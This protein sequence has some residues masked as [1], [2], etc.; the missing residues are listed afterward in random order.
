MKKIIYN[1]LIRDKIPEI[2]RNDNQ[3][4]KIQILK[5]KEFIKELKNKVLEEGKELIEAK[6]KKE[7]LDELIDLQEL[8]VYIIKENKISKS[9]I[10]RKRKEKNK[11]RGS[12]KKRLFLE[13]V[14]DVKK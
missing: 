4:P 5:K 3:I 9:E 12:F 14:K 6:T 1:K 8:I 2:I 10:T 13:Y 11:N 7:I